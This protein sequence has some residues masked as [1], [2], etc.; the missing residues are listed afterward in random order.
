V[1]EN[2]GRAIGLLNDFGHR[3]GFAGAGDAEKDLMLVAGFQ[4]IEE[5]I[6][7][8]G[9]IAARLVVAVQL[10]FHRERLLPVRRAW[11]KRSLYSPLAS[12]GFFG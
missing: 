12:C 5:L 10:E 3:E 4:A 6:D 8:G 9:L 7:G 11:Q 2:E 1:S